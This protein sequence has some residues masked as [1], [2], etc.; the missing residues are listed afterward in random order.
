[1]EHHRNR[2]A[3]DGARLGRIVYQDT[4][5]AQIERYHALLR[6]ITPA[7]RLKAA[8]SLSAGIRALAEAG[9]RMRHPTATDNEVSVRLTV[10]LYG[11][12]AARRL[13]GGYPDDAV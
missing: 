4:S 10:R 6:R 2:F 7:R 1:M 9:I 3:P 8:A 5:P 11:R 12:D 13:F